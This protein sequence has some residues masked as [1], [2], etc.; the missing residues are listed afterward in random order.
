M[1]GSSG[2]VVDLHLRCVSDTYNFDL[3][4]QFQADAGNQIYGQWT[5]RSRNIGGNAVGRAR[6]DVLQ[7]H[8]ES[9]GFSANV[10]MVTRGK[11]QAVTI[12][13]Q[14]GGQI[15]NASISLRRN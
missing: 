9:A 13:S 14:G 3:T 6:G 12:N 10:G 5:E 1:R 4:G 11:R 2:N 7:V 15:V 8:V